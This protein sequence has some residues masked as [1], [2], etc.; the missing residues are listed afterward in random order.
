LK[1][2]LGMLITCALL[3]AQNAEELLTNGIEQFHKGQYAAARNSFEKT[4]AL[5]PADSRALAYLAV[6]RASLGECANTLSELRHQFER[7]RDPELRKSTGIAIIECL[8]PRNEFDEI[9]STLGELEKRFPSDPDVLYEAAH[10]HRL[11]WT[12]SMGRLLRAAPDSWRAHQ[13]SAEVLENQGRWKEA[14]AEYAKAI[15]Q[16]PSALRLHY[17]LGVVLRHDTADLEPARKEFQAELALNPLD[18]AAEYY[19]GD[20]DLAQDKPIEAAGHFEQALKRY[21]QFVEAL[22]GLGRAKLALQQTAEAIHSLE[23]AVQIQPDMQ[24]AHH[25]LMLAY[26]AAGKNKQ[27]QHEE[28]LSQKLE[29]SK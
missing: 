28:E 11:G 21:S 8:L 2:F 12:Y 25:H 13:L 26:R 15:A 1:H 9:L 3:S 17:Q 14:S 4:L 23:R 5:S 7:N 24:A 6:T 10:V 19:L 29:K 22:V 18:V 20:I 27:A 16:N